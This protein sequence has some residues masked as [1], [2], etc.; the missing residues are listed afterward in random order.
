MT[1]NEI[2]ETSGNTREPLYASTLGAIFFLV[3]LGF[4]SFAGYKLNEIEERI[5]DRLAYQPP[6]TVSSVESNGRPIFTASHAHTIYVPVYSHIY[7]SGGTPVLLESTLSIRNTDSDH[8]IM[9]T[10]ANYYDTKGN[11]VEEYLDGNLVLGPLE[12][13]ELLVKKQDTRGGSGAN[14]LV[15]WTSVEPVHLPIV[16][17]IMVGGQDDIQVSLRTNGQP[18]TSRIAPEIKE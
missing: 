8:D 1:K 2:D 12:S 5:E 15:T 6:V 13:S 11:L 17:A 10:S 18:L 16:Q 7:A 9:I 3:L 14:F 4:L